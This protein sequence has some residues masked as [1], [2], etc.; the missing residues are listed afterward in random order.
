VTGPCTPNCEVIG[1]GI[2]SITW[3]D[4]ANPGQGVNVSYYS[5]PDQSKDGAFE[6]PTDPVVRAWS[7][8]SRALSERVPPAAGGCGWACAAGRGWLRV[9]VCCLPAA[10][11]REVARRRPCLSVSPGVSA[12][13]LPHVRASP[14]P[15]A[16]PPAPPSLPSDQGPPRPLRQDHDHVRPD[17]KHARHWRAL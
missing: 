6:C 8:S 3:M 15:C 12:A 4:P 14:Y 11:S 17:R 5:V 16:C 2:P 13:P 1:V 10:R 7:V 9:G